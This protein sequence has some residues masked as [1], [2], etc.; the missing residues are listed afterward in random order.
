MPY[1]AGLEGTRGVGGCHH[2]AVGQVKVFWTFSDLCGSEPMD[3][4]AVH[5]RVLLAGLSLE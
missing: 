1:F 3:N 5:G 2:L 4:Q